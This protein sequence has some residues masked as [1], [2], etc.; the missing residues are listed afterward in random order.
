MHSWRLIV[1]AYI[2]AMATL[3]ALLGGAE[4]PFGTAKP[5]DGTPGLAPCLWHLDVMTMDHTGN[6]SGMEVT[7][8]FRSPGGS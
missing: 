6:I 3:V 2:V 5:D 8:A 4:H 1:A 7:C